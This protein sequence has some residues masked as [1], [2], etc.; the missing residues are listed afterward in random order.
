MAQP[1]FTRAQVQEII[2]EAL[3]AVHITQ[4]AHQGPPGPPGPEGP[5]GPQGPKADSTSWKVEDLGFFSPDLTDPKDQPIKSVGTQVHYRDVY[6]F[7]DRLKDFATIK[8]EELVKSNVHAS[9]RGSALDWYST[10]LTDRE[11]RY[12]RLAT[13]QDGWIDSLIQR[14]K[15]RT[16]LALNKLTEARYALS[17]LRDG[18]SPRAF[19]QTILRHAKAAQIDSLYNQL[20]MIWAKLDTELRRDVPEPTETTSMADFMKQLEAKEDIWKELA[21]QRFLSRSPYPSTYPR[22]QQ[23]T[24]GFT[25]GRNS[26]PPYHGQRPPSQPSYYAQGSPFRPPLTHLPNEQG[27]TPTAYQW[28]TPYTPQPPPTRGYNMPFQPPMATFP[29]PW[30]PPQPTQPTQPRSRPTNPTVSHDQKQL[31]GQH[32]QLLLA[33]KPAYPQKEN[34]YASRTHQEFKPRQQWNR[35]QTAYLTAPYDDNDLDYP[36]QYAPYPDTN[37]ETFEEDTCEQHL[38]YPDEFAPDNDPA[39]PSVQDTQSQALHLSIDTTPYACLHCSTVLTSNNKLHS[40]LRSIHSDKQDNPV[41]STT[42]SVQPSTKREVITSTHKI[43]DSPGYAFKSWRFL[44]ANI[45]LNAPSGPIQTEA[46]IDTGCTM[47]VINKDLAT[48]LGFTTSKTQ[49]VPVAGIG[50]K[51]ASTEFATIE[52]DIPATIGSKEVLARFNLEAHLLEGLSTK[53]LIGTDVLVP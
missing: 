37:P 18:T 40:H 24:Y 48:A 16:A 32:K 43:T 13:L 25:G 52:V 5:P 39:Y 12:L 23:N 8:G 6:V 38:D 33:D 14:F 42:P 31:E 7:T 2:A 53:L 34:R 50:S 10:E 3:A 28:R 17:D 35:S 9:L 15:P 46:C 4:P 41:S 21:T 44:T 11:K 26:Q 30:H 20:T 22:P 27:N 47:T 29:R 19:A 36:D 51:H 49:P 1:T 45:I